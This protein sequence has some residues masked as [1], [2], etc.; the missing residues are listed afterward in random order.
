M[1]IS[2]ISSAKGLK[3]K[4]CYQDSSYHFTVGALISIVSSQKDNEFLI[5]SYGVGVNSNEMKPAICKTDSSS[6]QYIKDLL[7]TE[8]SGSS[9]C[10]FSIEGINE[11]SVEVQAYIF[12]SIK[13]FKTTVSIIIS[14]KLEKTTPDTLRK[15]YTWDQL[16]E[17]AVFC[18]NY[19]SRKK[20]NADL[21]FLSGKRYLI[22]HNTVRGIIA[23]SEN[24]LRDKDYLPI[25][26]IVAPS[27]KFIPAS[28]NASENNDLVAYL[29]RVS[30]PQ[31]YFARWEAYNELS[32]K[33][34][35]Q[36]SE[37]FGEVK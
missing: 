29:D 16:G 37:E 34:I 22:A 7:D 33:L 6:S 19:K 26:V 1:K 14:E 12:N 2:D 17:P 8:K 18:L 25:D 10:L 15:E 3:L 30:N 13:T 20:Q 28:E 27:I 5:D 24:Y 31:S 9:R 36:E 23:E 4:L 11:D 21:R 32:K 35:E